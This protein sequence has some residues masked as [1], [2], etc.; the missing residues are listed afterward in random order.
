M[1]TLASCTFPVRSS[2]DGAVLDAASEFSSPGG[3]SAASAWHSALRL[4]GEDRSCCS[5]HGVTRTPVPDV[6]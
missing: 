3:T 5:A 6:R 4:S 2:P 1:S